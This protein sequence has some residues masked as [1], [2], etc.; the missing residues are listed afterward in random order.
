MTK[1]AV[2]V[3]QKRFLLIIASCFHKNGVA[4]HK[5]RFVFV[6]KMARCEQ[7]YHARSPRKQNINS[8]FKL[9]GY[10]ASLSMTANKALR[11]IATF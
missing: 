1:S 6:R 2:I 9:Y 3:L 4:S 5:F 7:I 11:Q 10:F 8:H